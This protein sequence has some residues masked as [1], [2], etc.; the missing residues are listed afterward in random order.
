MEPESSETQNHPARIHVRVIGVLDWIFS[1]YWTAMLVFSLI[2]LDEGAIWS[3]ILMISFVMTVVHIPLAWGIWRFKNWAR[4]GQ[5]LLSVLHILL[6]PLAVYE[7][8]WLRLSKCGP[9]FGR[10]TTA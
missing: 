7:W 5:L 2:Q 1:L 6:L 10:G 3:P 9:L 4:V 8:Y